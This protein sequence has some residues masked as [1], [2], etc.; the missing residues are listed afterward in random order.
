[1]MRAFFALILIVGAVGCAPVR[2]V[3]H[4]PYYYD[5]TQKPRL[6]V[7][8]MV[9]S[10]GCYVPWHID[11]ELT[12]TLRYQLMCD[13]NLY[14]LPE[15]EVK[16]R[17]NGLEPSAFFSQDLT[18]AKQFCE[19]DYLVAL[20]LIEHEFVPF[21]REKVSA[22]YPAQAQR[23][24]SMLQ[25][26]LRLRVIDLK[27]DCPRVI[28]QEIFTSNSM[29]P[30]ESECLDYE[31]YRWGTQT[32]NSTPMGQAHRRLVRDLSCRIENVIKSL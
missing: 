27:S 12:N 31:K 22:C 1:M 17:A 14:L 18:F 25:I 30:K 28:L 5:G 29:I 9:D 10:S 26:K 15:E 6:A 16:L 3:E 19:T 7:I 13:G 8:Q 11:Q 2:P 4:F 20:D 21:A 32:F 24:S 23:C